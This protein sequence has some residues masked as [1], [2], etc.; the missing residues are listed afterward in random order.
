M[1]SL[2]VYR[3]L[4]VC[5]PSLAILLIFISLLASIGCCVCLNLHKGRRLVNRWCFEILRLALRD[6]HMNVNGRYIIYD[7]DIGPHSFAVLVVLTVLVIISVLF[8]TFWNIYMVEEKIGRD[9]SPHYDCFPIDDHGR[10]LQNYPVSNCSSWPPDTNYKCYRLVYAYVQGVSAT[11][12]LMF[13][14]SVILK[15]YIATLLAP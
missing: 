9:C 7:E 13:F 6:L 5:I 15:M 3:A 11:G 14:A 8:I 2:T 10:S 1:P 12:G 4:D